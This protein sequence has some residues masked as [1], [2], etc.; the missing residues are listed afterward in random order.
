[1]PPTLTITAIFSLMKIAY[2]MILR[3]LLKSA[4]DDPSQEWDNLV[5]DMLD[6]I[7]DYS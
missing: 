1:M 6:K 2:K 3:D 5:L 4:I 7:F